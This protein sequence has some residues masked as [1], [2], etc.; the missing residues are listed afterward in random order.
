MQRTVLL[1]I[2]CLGLLT[3]CANRQP[4][5]VA[6]TIPAHHLHPAVVLPSGGE[7]NFMPRTPRIGTPWTTDAQKFSFVIFGDKTGGD[8]SGWPYFDR[9]VDEVN[10]LRPDFVIMVGDMIP[11]HFNTTELEAQW[12]DFMSHARR[13]RV[14]F[15][16][17]PGNHDVAGPDG[18]SL[19]YWLRNV[20]RTY[21]SFD[22]KDCHFLI[23]N[24]CET[25]GGFGDD[26]VQFAL[27]DL[28][29]HRD[30]RHTFVFLHIPTWNYP[31]NPAQY[32]MHWTQIERVLGARDYTVFA[33]HRHRLQY[34]KRFSRR[35]IVLGPTGG[36]QMFPGREGNGELPLRELGQFQHYTNVTVDGDSVHLAI[37]EPGGPMWPCDVAPSRIYD[38]AVELIQPEYRTPDPAARTTGV[39]IRLNN[40]LPE[41]AHV[42]ARILPGDNWRVTD[43]PDSISMDLQPGVQDSIVI[44]LHA[45]G[46]MLPP[47]RIHYGFSYKGHTIGNETREF[48]VVPRERMLRLAGWQLAGPFDV[49]S[50]TIEALRAAGS[51]PGQEILTPRGPETGT[52]TVFID[53]GRRI[54]WNDSVRLAHIGLILEMAFPGQRNYLAYGV[55]R[56]HS[57]VAQQAFMTLGGNGFVQVFINGEPTDGGTFIERGTSHVSAV[58][59]REGTN[60][61]VFKVLASVPDPFAWGGLAGLRENLQPVPGL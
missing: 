31:T 2:C 43:G 61:V 54:A 48:P 7:P 18:V 38:A 47:P 41:S 3:S 50:T 10:L 11:G 25:R 56:V 57:P 55:V 4:Q 24:S 33:G 58:N 21:Y 45:D 51:D 32:T 42:N 52:D 13:L 16:M 14:P 53:N 30:V 44:R 35:F 15:L 37:I 26:Q 6:P 59:L 40:A 12:A 46:D 36:S 8:E 27:E 17:I 39:T 20:G 29:R 9:A 49:D 28:E 22:Y 34:Q 23:L 5:Q 60:T 1:A 19:D